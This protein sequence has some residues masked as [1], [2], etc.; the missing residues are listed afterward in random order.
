MEKILHLPWKEIYH[1]SHSFAF[2]GSGK[3]LSISRTSTFGPLNPFYTLKLDKQGRAA[4]PVKIHTLTPA[5][6]K[7]LC[8]RHPASDPKP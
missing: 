5:S 4:A 8:R 2:A 7:T 1:E 3:I 6:Q